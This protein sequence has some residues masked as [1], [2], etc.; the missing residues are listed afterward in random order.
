MD[1]LDFQLLNEYLFDDQSAFGLANSGSF[2]SNGSLGIPGNTE[3]G[4][5]SSSFAAEQEQAGSS[6]PA[7]GTAKKPRKNTAASAS[8][9]AATGNR[10]HG[11]GTKKRHD[12]DEDDGDSGV[13][14]PLPLPPRPATCACGHLL[15]GAAGQDLCL[16]DLVHA[17]R[18]QDERGT[19]EELEGLASTDEEED[20]GAGGK[21]RKVNP[22]RPKTQ[23]QI[24][25]RRERNRI[26]ARRTRLRKKFFFE[27]L[28]EQV[29]VG[30]S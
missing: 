16:D 11:A 15:L 2:G 27:G 17:R 29:R 10:G 18:P 8:Q 30:V 12:V 19:D 24:D 3:T 13:H 5:G 9:R 1:T 25:R 20:D 26:L 22:D 4:G 14:S 23:A 7:R 21:R 28:Q 6:I